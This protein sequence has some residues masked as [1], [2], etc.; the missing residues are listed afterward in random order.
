MAWGRYGLPCPSTKP[1]DKV[2]RAKPNNG[3]M[4]GTNAVKPNGGRHKAVPHMPMGIS[5]ERW[6][7]WGKAETRMQAP[8]N[9]VFFRNNYA[10]R[11]RDAEGCGSNKPGTLH[12]NDMAHPSRDIAGVVLGG[13]NFVLKPCQGLAAAE[14]AHKTVVTQELE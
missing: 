2:Y 12:P 9:R 1:S 3:A 10:V 5:R 14:H 13:V 4:P 8:E 11:N 6:M 7:V